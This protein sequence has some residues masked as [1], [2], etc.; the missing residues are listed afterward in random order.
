MDL[1][2]PQDFGGLE[3]E[4]IPKVICVVVEHHPDRR[5]A[6]PGFF[7]Q[8]SERVPK[9]F[10]FQPFLESHR[11]GP[12]GIHVRE[13]FVKGLPARFTSESPGYDGETHPFPV[14]REVPNPILPATEA[15][16]SIGTAM[17]AAFGRR[18]GLGLDVVAPV[19]VLD[20]ENLIE[21]KVQD[22]RFPSLSFVNPICFLF[23]T[24]GSINC[25]I[26]SNNPIIASS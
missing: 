18:N 20:L 4:G 21:G 19:G 10:L 15:H 5:I 13:E 2:D 17:D 7:G 11:H 8:V 23:S 14:D 6:D 26:A 3:P 24:G 22:V 9:G 16:Q 1:V 25:R 12:F